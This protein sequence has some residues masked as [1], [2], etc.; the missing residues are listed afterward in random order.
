METQDRQTRLLWSK[1]NHIAQTCTT[2]ASCLQGVVVKPQ[3][4]RGSHL[5]EVPI[6]LSHTYRDPPALLVAYLLPPGIALCLH[7]LVLR[8][9][10]K[11]WKVKEVRSRL[12]L[13][14]RSNWSVTLCFEVQ[15]C[16]IEEYS[17]AL[18]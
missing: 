16:E 13:T 1:L 8:P 7:Y 12:G 15:S 10:R 17:M 4:S 3:F 18:K 11:H 5:F 2:L 14:S 9:L 6:A